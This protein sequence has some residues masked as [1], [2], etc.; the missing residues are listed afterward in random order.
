MA[1]NR[2]RKWI[3]PSL[4]IL[5]LAA[6]GGA[7][8]RI[9][10]EQASAASVPS[11]QETSVRKGDIRIDFEADAVASISYAEAIAPVAGTLKELQVELGDI[12]VQGDLLAQLDDA[13]ARQ[14][15]ADAE[16]ALRDAE[17]D[18]EQ[19]SWKRTDSLQE[20]KSRIALLELQVEDARRE[21]ES[22]R[23]APEAFSRQEA[24]NAASQLKN[25][26]MGLDAVREAYARLL[27][28][29][30]DLDM[31]ELDVENARRGLEEARAALEDTRVVAPISGRVIQLPLLPG[32]MATTA[33]EIA[34]IAAEDGMEIQARVSELDVADLEADQSVEVV[35]E[36]LRDTPFRGR[37]V[38]IDPLAQTD[39]NG[40]VSY[41]VLLE[42]EKRDERILD[43]MTGTVSFIL[44][45]RTTVLILPN[46]AIRMVDG[47]QIVEVKTDSGTVMAKPVTTGLTDGRNVE[48]LS[49]LAA[50]EVVLLRE[51]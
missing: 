18:R 32:D 48:I 47:V 51:N 5:A 36:A 38:L 26:E 31:A 27:A 20:E 25:E 23:L 8:L 3:M 13:E 30:T 16:A 2:K 34:W 21:L 17:L 29:A 35:F 7:Y 1:V 12:V 28:D 14:R 9:A 41:S 44:R 4:L 11:Y 49:G 40:L 45:E 37:V 22:I 15:I 19:T 24:E 10:Q 43:G 42:L 6:G 46:A 39:A 50:G 33:A